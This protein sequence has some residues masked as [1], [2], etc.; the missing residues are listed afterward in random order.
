MCLVL[1]DTVKLPT[2]W[3][4]L[5]YRVP[6]EPSKNRVAVWRDMKRMGALYLQNCVCLLPN[7]KGVR[8]NMKSVRARVDELGG[9]SNVFETRRIDDVDAIVESFQALSD[10]EYAEIMEECVTKFQK[11][12]EFERFRKNFS[13]E[14]AEEIYADLEKIKD[15]LARV[16]NRDW[17]GSPRRLEAER[18][19]TQSEQL[20]DEFER[21]CFAASGDNDERGIGPSDLA[22]M[23]SAIRHAASKRRGR[24]RLPVT[25]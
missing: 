25:H 19:V 15:W 2:S 14:E 21:E 18:L 3:F 20:Y 4:I 1:A 8:Q 17:F 24:P 12:I 23:K 7:F 16:V 10:R 5:I 11:E 22:L 6:T 9:S 13:Y